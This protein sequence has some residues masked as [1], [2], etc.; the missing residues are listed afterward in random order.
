MTLEAPEDSGSGSGDFEED[1]SNDGGGMG[2]GVRQ[3]SFAN[4]NGDL[5]LKGGEKLL[6]PNDII[7]E[8]SNEVSYSFQN[9]IANDEN[10]QNNINQNS[11][12]G[13]DQNGKNGKERNDDEEEEE[14][15]E[16]DGPGLSMDARTT[17][18][19]N[20]ASLIPRTYGDTNGAP[21][22]LH[23]NNENEENKNSGHFTNKSN[24]VAPSESTL[25]ALDEMKIRNQ[26]K[27]KLLGYDPN[28]GQGNMKGSITLSNF[29]PTTIMFGSHSNHSENKMNSILTNNH[30][31]NN[32]KLPGNL[33]SIAS[34]DDPSQFQSQFNPEFEENDSFSSNVNNN[35]PNSSLPNSSVPKSVLQSYSMCIKPPTKQIKRVS[36][37]SDNK[38]FIVAKSESDSELEEE[39]DDNPLPFKMD[40]N[41]LLAPIQNP[42]DLRIEVRPISPQWSQMLKASETLDAAAGKQIDESKMTAAELLFGANAQTILSENNSENESQEQFYEEEEEEEFIENPNLENP[43]KESMNLTSIQTVNETN[44]ENS[45][46]SVR[47]FVSECVKSV[48]KGE[49]SDASSTKS[50]RSEQTPSTLPS[51]KFSQRSKFSEVSQDSHT[52][53]NQSNSK[54][55]HTLIPFSQKAQKKLSGFDYSEFDDPNFDYETEQQN[56]PQDLIPLIKHSNTSIIF[57]AICGESM[58]KYPRKVV[59]FVLEDLKAYLQFCINSNMITESAYLSGRIDDIKNDIQISVQQQNN[60]A[61]EKRFQEAEDNLDR[62]QQFWLTQ[63]QIINSELEVKL[64]EIELRFQDEMNNLEELWNTDQKKMQYN[65]PSAQLISLR[66]NIQANLVGKRFEEASKLAMKAEEMDK[67]E[68]ENAYAKMQQAFADAANRLRHKFENEKKTVIEQYDAKMCSVIAQEKSDITPIEQRT[69]NYQS[70][71]DDQ[72]CSTQPISSLQSQSPSTT[73]GSSNLTKR[74]INC[75]AYSGPIMKRPLIKAPKVTTVPNAKLVLPSIKARQNLSPF[76]KQSNILS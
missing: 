18:F 5:I 37:S 45:I 41:A 11:S 12:R 6:N 76:N 8:E 71:F 17:T 26:E 69:K 2:L 35:L 66:Q 53:Q 75:L 36:S 20:L 73:S 31:N 65:K 38:K 62:K 43:V 9:A 64:Q 48:R 39:N 72:K 70:A 59:H 42:E 74:S 29:K 14:E 23:G 67:I 57:R 50:I 24:L 1:Y 7:A 49:V 30:Q 40:T 27:W 55:N 52:S 60:Q 61:A 54:Q 33:T 47:E 10:N 15:E 16:F 44:D 3:P 51:T 13:E 4:L 46:E 63:K 25:N 21:S 58:S 19:R 56:I 68:T 28:A 22:I 32:N 34:S